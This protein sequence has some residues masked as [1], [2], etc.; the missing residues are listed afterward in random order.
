MCRGHAQYPVFAPAV[1]K[2]QLGFRS[3][4]ILLS[5]TF[6]NWHTQLFIVSLY[7]VAQGDAASTA[8]KSPRFQVPACLTDINTYRALSVITQMQHCQLIL[9]CFG[10]KHS[11]WVHSFSCRKQKPPLVTAQSRE[12]SFLMGSCVSARSLQACLKLCNPL[13]VTP[14]APLSMGFSRQEYWSGLPCPPPGDLPDTK[15]EPISVSPALAG[16][17]FTTRAPGKHMS[18]YFSPLNC[19]GYIHIATSVTTH[20]NEC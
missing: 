12:V 14:Q 13:G 6:P 7:F 17:F 15:V 5:I 9:E 2:Q 20:T 4:Y 8:A 10:S 18:L 19:G 3:L 1:Q 11:K 16:G